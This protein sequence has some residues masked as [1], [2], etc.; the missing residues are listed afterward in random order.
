MRLLPSW[1][2]QTCILGMDFAVPTHG[3]FSSIN[4][5]GL[6]ECLIRQYNFIY[7]IASAK[8]PLLYS[9]ETMGFTCCLTHHIIDATSM[10]EGPAEARA[11]T[12]AWI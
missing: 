5:E 11:E 6:T 12:P 1:R 9:K 4:T 2:D 8:D 7:N 10:I 3:A